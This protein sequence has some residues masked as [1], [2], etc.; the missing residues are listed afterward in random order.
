MRITGRMNEMSRWASFVSCFLLSSFFFPTGFAAAEITDEEQRRLELE[1]VRELKQT[2]SPTNLRTTLESQI[3]SQY[4]L[5]FDYGGSV[6]IS[7][8]GSRDD[9][10]NSATVDSIDH[11]YN[12]E[13]SGYAQL[14]DV[15]RLN[16]MYIRSRTVYSE[17]KKNGESSVRGNDWREPSIE[18]IYFEKNISASKYHHTIRVGRQF[19][20]VG[21]GITFSKIADGLYYRAND[22]GSKFVYELYGMEGRRRDNNI[23]VYLSG[24][25]DGAGRDNRRFGGGG[26]TW[27]YKPMQRVHV[28]ALK[29]L[30]RN[31][32]THP[33][34]GRV[35][36]DSKYYGT[37][38][39]GRMTSELSYW[40]EFIRMRGKDFARGTT[41]DFATRDPIRASAVDAGLE[42]SFSAV[43]G[44]PIINA[45]YSVASG[46]SRARSPVG[47]NLTAGNDPG[48]DDRSFQSFGG[49]ELGYAF[50]PAFSN[51]RVFQLGGSIQPMHD[52][53]DDFLKQTR[54]D[55]TWYKFRM[56]DRTGSVSDAVVRVPS[57]SDDLGDEWNLNLRVRYTSDF[58]GD[59][60]A[61][62]FKPGPAYESSRSKEVYLRYLFTLDI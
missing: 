18:M 38:W 21:R 5:L 45:Q 8:T 20:T 26:I 25:M 48:T 44:R 33:Q 46:D 32:D 23:A 30:D 4:R 36:L 19:F 11:Y 16:R 10:R 62:V 3:L 40:G 43:A 55:L 41:S 27:R 6:R 47:S 14:S 39:S 54:L 56:Y 13:M 34:A 22:R 51:I 2:E 57:R 59:F 15:S 61:G 1:P 7:Y 35:R 24:Q 58:K 17:F 31:P 29:N 49:L 53:P 52:S 60:R 28:Y 42:Y 12:Y 50:T 9:D 37:V